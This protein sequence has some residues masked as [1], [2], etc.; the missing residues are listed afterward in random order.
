MGIRVAQAFYAISSPYELG[1]GET[2]VRLAA[3]AFAHGDPLYP[4]TRQPPYRLLNYP[5]LYPALC[6]LVSKVFGPGYAPGRAVSWLASLLTALLIGALV[7]RETQRLDASLL[8]AGLYLGSWHVDNSGHSYRVDSLSVSLGLLGLALVV[9]AGPW[10]WAAGGAFLLAILTRQSAIAGGAAALLWLVWRGQ[11]RRAVGLAAIWLGGAG[12]A[13][14]ALSAA[15][16]GRFFSQAVLML[17][18]GWQVDRVLLFWGDFIRFY[19]VLLALACFAAAGEWKRA[20][21]PTPLVLYAILAALVSLSVGKTGSGEN[22]L[23]APLAGVCMLVGLGWA[24]LAESAPMRA[25]V[26][27]LLVVQLLVMMPSPRAEAAQATLRRAQRDQLGSLLPP[28]GEPVLSEDPSVLL[29][30]GRTVWLLPYEFTQAALQGRW[31]EKPVVEDI[32]AGRFALIILEFNPWTAAPGADGSYEFG[33]F[34]GP[35]VQAIK[36]R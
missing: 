30:H 3:E 11:R 1:Y 20:A 19:P 12:V 35:M 18:T 15:T 21:R 5:P 16:G 25:L 7:K 23:L 22:Y 34:T 13:Y 4:D 10:V 33:R 27:V 29:A 14:L 28:K 17:R 8:A 26:Q 9:R 31:D 6:G 32:E 24:H 2:Q 36:R